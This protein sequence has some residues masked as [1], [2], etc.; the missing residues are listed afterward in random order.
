MWVDGCIRVSQVAGR[1]GER[2]ISPSLP[3]EQIEGWVRAR[4]YLLGELFEELDESGA[5]ADGGVF[6]KAIFRTPWDAQ[7]S[8]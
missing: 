8:P 6:A 4:G 3:R 7:P 1:T 5:R 2:F